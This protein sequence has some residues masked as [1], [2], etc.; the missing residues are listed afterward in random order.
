MATEDFDTVA[1]DLYALRP[2]DFTAARNVRAAAARTA[3]DRALA[4]RIGALRRPSLSAWASNLLVREQPREAQALLRLGEGLRQ[5]HHDLD[6]AQLRE[7]SRRQHALITE[8]SRR[9]RQL[10]A[11]SGHPVGDEVQ[12][13][14]EATLHAVLADPDAAR[15]WAGGRLVRPLSAAVGFPAAAPTAV[16]S[17][18]P[19]APPPDRAAPAARRDTRGEE[20]RRQLD[21]ARTAAKDAERELREREDEAAGARREAEEAAER[22]GRLQR[23]ADALAEE[24]RGVKDEQQRARAAERAAQRQARDAGQRVTQARRRAEEAAAQVR[25]LT[26]R[27]K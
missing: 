14:V 6:G 5:A 3:G 16:P 9:A 21:R 22:A 23:R 27:D 1:D 7:L 8:L 4:E 20:R 11:R 26:A 15:E 18:A 24:L 17:R 10:A 2:E 19:A 25:R 13:E 12:H